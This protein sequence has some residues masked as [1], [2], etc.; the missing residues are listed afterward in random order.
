MKYLMD[1]NN[2]EGLGTL[3][4]AA[5]MYC[6]G[7]KLAETNSFLLSILQSTKTN[8]DLLTESDR[9]AI[10]QYVAQKA[11][12]LCFSSESHKLSPLTIDPN[13]NWVSQF[14]LWIQRQDVSDSSASI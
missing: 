14:Y 8:W 11:N 3:T 13:D 9:K 4:I 12:E 2:V 10:K 5:L 1:K 6:V 7:S